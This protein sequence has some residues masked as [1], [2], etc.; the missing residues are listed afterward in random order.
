MKVLRALRV[1]GQW[2]ILNTRTVGARDIHT[3]AA[4]ITY[5]ED[6][7]IKAFVGR[8]QSNAIVTELGNITQVLRGLTTASVILKGDKITLDDGT[9]YVRDTPTQTHR[10]M[11][12]N[13]RL[14]YRTTIVRDPLA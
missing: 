14:V 4:A 10:G 13:E 8:A 2:V 12:S 11:G 6:Q 3:G 1:H 9:Y 7:N 5:G